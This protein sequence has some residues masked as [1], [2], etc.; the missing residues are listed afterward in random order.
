[1]HRSKTTMLKKEKRKKEECTGNKDKP[2]LR[3][4]VYIYIYLNTVILSFLQTSDLNSTEKNST[5]KKTN[6]YAA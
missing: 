1:M 4:R 6:L 5:N 2:L 3:S